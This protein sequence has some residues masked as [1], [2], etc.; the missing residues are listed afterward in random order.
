MHTDMV[1]ADNQAGELSVAVVDSPVVV[2]ADIPA[3]LPVMV[4][5]DIPAVS[6]PVVAVL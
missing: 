1:V 3:V 2:V 6:P 4:V 5:A